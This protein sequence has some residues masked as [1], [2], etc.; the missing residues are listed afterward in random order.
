MTKEQRTIEVGAELFAFTTFT[1]WV[2][3]ARGWYRSTGTSS[4]NSIAIDAAGRVCL[5]GVHFMRARDENTFPVR[6]YEIA[7]DRA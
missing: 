5:L 1:Q 6:V 2:N 3:K 7:M 4:H